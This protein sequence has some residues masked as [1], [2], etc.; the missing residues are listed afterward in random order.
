MGVHPTH[1]PMSLQNYIDKNNSK[2]HIGIIATILAAAPCN[3]GPFLSHNDKNFLKVPVSSTVAT[4]NAFFHSLAAITQSQGR[5]LTA[6]AI[7]DDII[8]RVNQYRISQ[9]KKSVKHHA[10][11]DKIALRHA[12][13]M[14]QNRDKARVSHAFHN[15][16]SYEAYGS[17]GMMGLGENVGY[18]ES[19]SPARHLVSMW[20][21][22]S[23]HRKNMLGQWQYTGIG[24]VI[25]PDGA[26][27]A[28]QLFARD[29]K[30]QQS[31]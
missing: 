1:K 20:I 7:Q 19:S 10:G 5:G 3:A 8:R 18:T 25:A 11:L 9:G 14:M 26:V 24:V 2:I 27:F 4:S 13:Y 23:G 29:Y 22:S 28:T 12:K 30:L 16:R 21:Q 17:Y 31:P 6:S 15:R